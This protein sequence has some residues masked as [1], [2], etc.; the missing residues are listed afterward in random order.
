MLPDIAA[1]LPTALTSNGHDLDCGPARLGWLTPSDPGDDLA[2]LRARY[3]ADGYLW[4]KSLLP[5]PAVLEFRRHVFA[6]FAEFGLLAAGSDPVEGRASDRPSDAASRSRMMELVRSAAFESFC[7]T[8]ELWRFID[9]LI[10]GMSTLHKRK[11]LRFT[12][13]GDPA[14]TG[15]HYDLIY[16]RA[17]TDRLV[18]A[19]IPIGDVPV[20]MGGLLYL[21]GSHRLGRTMEA[22]F[23]LKNA[24]LSPEERI[25]AYNRNM[26]ETGWISKNLPEMAERF[27]TRWLAAD[28]TAGDVV[29]HSPYM[30]HAATRNDDPDGIMRLSAD[31]RFQDVRDEADPRW[32]RH[33]ATDDGL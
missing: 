27:A 6:Q 19:W 12:R 30:I 8:P 7:L 3:E 17:G 26:T 28:Y 11:I 21:E 29:L 5:R 22:E 2:T 33:W 13:P 16:L 25:S 10:G 15:A 9:R 14:A 23:A 31:I 4:L 20:R 24:E 1:P 32:G 18:T